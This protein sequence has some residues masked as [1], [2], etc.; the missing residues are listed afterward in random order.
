MQE[1]A[2]YSAE[3]DVKVA[4]AR[5]KAAVEIAKVN[6]LNSQFYGQANELPS[7]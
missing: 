3:R 2:K 7:W 6:A 4:E 5:G 1:I